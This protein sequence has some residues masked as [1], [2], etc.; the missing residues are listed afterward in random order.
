MFAV[1]GGLGGGGIM[2]PLIMIFMKMPIQECVPLANIFAMISAVT[3][4]VY[5]FNQTHPYR[6]FKKIIDYEIV[7][8]TIPCNPW[9]T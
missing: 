1:A 5:N 2:I 7:T 6:P 8:L 3:R 4:F 9:M